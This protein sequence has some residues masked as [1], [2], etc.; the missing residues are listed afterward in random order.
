MNNQN[1]FGRFNYSNP[2]GNSNGSESFSNQNRQIMNNLYN[3]NQN[4]SES[5][6]SE[7]QKKEM[8]LENEIRDHLKC[9]ICLTK[10]NKPAMCKYCK[11]ICCKPCIDRWLLNHHFCGICKHEITQQDMILLPFLDDMSTYFIDNIDNHP[12]HNPNNN[13]NQNNIGRKKNNN[14]NN[15]N[16]ESENN[17]EIC[18]KHITKIDYYCIQCNKYFCSN[19]LVFFSEEGKKHQNHLV[20]P[21]AKMNDLGIKE[22][23]NQYKKLPQTKNSIEHLI[24]LINMRIKE[25][26]IKTENTKNFINQ[27]RDFYLSKIED[28]T[29]ELKTILTKLTSQ[30]DSIETSINSIPNGFSNIVN[31]NDFV[32]GNIV[33]KELKKFNRIDENLENEIKEKSDINPKLLIENYE[34]NLLEISIPYG[35]QYNEGLDIVHLKIDIIPNYPSTLIMRYLQGQIYISLCVDIDAPLNTFTYPK[36]YSYIIFKNLKYGAQ[37]VNLNQSLFQENRGNFGRIRQQINSTQFDA[38]QFVFLGGDDKKVRLKLYIIKT[39]Q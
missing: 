16:N 39:Y 28:N 35:G 26:E 23:I 12:K 20:L 31:R 33:S 18:Q 4:N 27:I 2:N 17:K 21:L 22:A 25:N 24:S 11:K 9:Y 38:N 19:C 5:N 10:V 8:Q 37:L 14:V 30:K 13:Q 6:Q 7:S 32:Q 3:N 29:R 34:T 36:F 15:N 1:N